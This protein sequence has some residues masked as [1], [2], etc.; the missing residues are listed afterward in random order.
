MKIAALKLSSLVVLL[1]GVLLI[2]LN[3]GCPYMQAGMETVNTTFAALGPGAL[4]YCAGTV[5]ILLGLYAFLPKV[6][7]KSRNRTVNTRLDHGNVITELDPLEAQ[8]ARVLAEMPEVKSIRVQL[9]PDKERRRVRITSDLVLNAGS[10]SRT[11]E[12]QDRVNRYV[13]ETTV[14]VFGLDVVEPVTLH[15]TGIELD[16]Q[17]VSKMLR[18]REANSFLAPLGVEEVRMAPVPKEELAAPASNTAMESETGLTL[19]EEPQNTES[20][21][22]PEAFY[23]QNE[24]PVTEP[25]PG[26]D[27][28]PLAAAPADVAEPS[29]TF[30]DLEKPAEEDETRE[31]QNR[32]S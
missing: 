28:E 22:V 31:A 26:L 30:E 5:L 20:A 14:A 32:W 15:V 2:G 12:T 13:T 7:R 23:V 24:E 19:D 11:S 10:D 4:N 8:L 6:P 18:D 1:G 27:L 25:E 29:S 9:T 17:A 21:V 16:P 3:L